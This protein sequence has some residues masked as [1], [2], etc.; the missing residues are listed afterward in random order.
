MSAR[1]YSTIEAAN[2]TRSST[3][4]W[5]KNYCQNGHHHGIKPVKQPSGRLLWPADQVD[6]LL[7]GEPIEA[8]QTAAQRV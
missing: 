5:R 4:T 8:I 7:S 1:F 3:S 2:A 6:R